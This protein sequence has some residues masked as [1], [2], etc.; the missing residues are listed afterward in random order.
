MKK[1]FIFLICIIGLPSLLSAETQEE[2]RRVEEEKREVLRPSEAHIT[3]AKPAPQPLAPIDLIYFTEL[4]PK[5][6]AYRYDAC[7]ALVVLMG[8]EDEYI[9]LDSQVAFLREKNLLPKRLESEFDPM[10]PLRRGL[11]AYMLCKALN[12]KGGITLSIF[13]V[14]ERYA[15]NELAFQGIMSSG[16]ANDIVSG[17]ELVLATMQAADY[18][19]KKQEKVPKSKR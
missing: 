17:D 10:Q 13:G 1:I 19:A 4:M 8:V 5:R 11:T 18:L 2:K 6:I 12:I 15:L 16:N 14:S 7:K 9:D 3:E